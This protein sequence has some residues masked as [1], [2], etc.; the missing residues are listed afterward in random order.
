MANK[1]AIK[2]CTITF[3]ETARPEIEFVGSW[4]RK[5]IIIAQRELLRGLM[6]YNAKLKK[7]ANKNG[8]RKSEG[9]A[10]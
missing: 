10:D 9:R 2:K 8:G 3:R 7:E 5:D 6:L 1:R 4:V